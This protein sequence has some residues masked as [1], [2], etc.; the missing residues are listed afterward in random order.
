[1]PW[2]TYIEK[3]STP[4][5]SSSL[6]LYTA[7]RFSHCTNSSQYISIPN[8][9]IQYHPRFENSPYSWWATLTASLCNLFF[10]VFLHSFFQANS[11]QE[12]VLYATLLNLIDPRPWSWHHHLLTQKSFPTPAAHMSNHAHMASLVRTPMCRNSPSWSFLL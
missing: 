10:E 11:E 9:L 3:I 4:S 12:E 8:L 6:I 1:M 2:L 5:A 7:R